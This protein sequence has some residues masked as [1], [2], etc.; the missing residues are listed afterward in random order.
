MEHRNPLTPSAFLVSRGQTAFFLTQ[1]K[2]KKVVWPCETTAFFSLIKILIV[3]LSYFAD[4]SGFSSHSIN[5]V[6]NRFESKSIFSRTICSVNTLLYRLGAYTN[7]AFVK[8]NINL[9]QLL[10]ITMADCYV[11]VFD[12]FCPRIYCVIVL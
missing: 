4:R 7:E 12:N 6:R 3:G 9:V 5:G 11:R 2:R 8:S 1:Y 10:F